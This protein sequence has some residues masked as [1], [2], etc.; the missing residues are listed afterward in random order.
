MKTAILLAT[1][2]ALFAMLA[3]AGGCTMSNQE[4]PD[5]AGPSELGLSVTVQVTPDVIQQD[6]ASQ[7]VLNITARDA[8]GDPA[9]NVPLRV[10]INV[11]GTAADFGSLSARN[12]VTDNNGRATVIYTAPAAV[13]GQAGVDTFTIVDFLVTP[14]G[15]NF[16]NSLPRIASVRLVPSGVVIPPAGF[17]VT[18][19][20][21][22]PLPLEGDT[23]FFNGSAS[24]GGPNNPIVSYRW[25]FGDGGTA[26]GSTATHAF[27]TAAVYQVTLTATDQHGRSAS[28][29]QT[30]RVNPGAPA[31][32]DIVISPTAPQPNQLVTMS[33]AAII[34]PAG[35]RFVSYEWNFGDGTPGASG[36]SVTHRYTAEG[37]FVVILTITDDV[38]RTTVRTREVQVAFPEEEA[39][40]GTKTIKR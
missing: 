1:R 28:S 4:P 8:N 20:F 37:N 33:A 13:A 14:L 9:R 10:E 3:L 26:S 29:T 27:N 40:T 21:S 16:N 24:T 23:V 35:R 15:D 18:F 31:T 38:G 22:P 19:T 7:S 32:G 17:N 36:S 25:T 11:N 39:I 30:V 12:V 5:L 6:G 2:T 34:P